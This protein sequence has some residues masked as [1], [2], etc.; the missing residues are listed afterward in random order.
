MQKF[1]ETLRRTGGLEAL[2]KLLS[3][4]APATRACVEALLPLVLGGFKRLSLASGERGEG[5]AGLE[6]RRLCEVVES[7]GGAEMAESVMAQSSLAEGEALLTEI[8]GGE[9]AV[10]AVCSAAAEKVDVPQQTLRAMLP[11]L[12]MLTGGYAYMVYYEEPEGEET[13]NA[14]LGLNEAGN[15]LDSVLRA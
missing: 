7:H 4:S 13:V 2:A 6:G 9:E 11:A 8:F 15:P 10:Q 5:K 3:L 12:A 1:M 14:L